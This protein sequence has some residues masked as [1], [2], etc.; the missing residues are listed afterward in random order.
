MAFDPFEGRTIKPFGGPSEPTK[1]SPRAAALAEEAAV[2]E[3]MGRA[4]KSWIYPLIGL[5][6]VLLFRFVLARAF[7]P[8]PE[9]WRWVLTGVVLLFLLG[10]LWRLVAACWNLRKYRRWGF[11]WPISLGLIVNLPMIIILAQGIGLALGID[12]EHEV[13][14]LFRGW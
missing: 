1:P 4:H 14:R 11:L 2:L 12:L 9:A 13:R 3:A 8:P 5:G 7:G 6:I 10:G